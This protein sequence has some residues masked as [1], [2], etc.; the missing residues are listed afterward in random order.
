MQ[1]HR[2][3]GAELLVRIRTRPVSANMRISTR[4]RHPAQKGGW[5]AQD[6][7]AR[8]EG[9]DRAQTE[10]EGEAEEGAQRGARRP[11][12]QS[13][14]VASSRALLLALLWLEAFGH[15]GGASQFSHKRAHA[16][17]VAWRSPSPAITRTLCAHTVQSP[18]APT[19][20][21]SLPT[22]CCACTFAPRRT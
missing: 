13:R 12:G 8:L 17:S 15:T 21:C 10:Q 9:G 5:S 14:M 3:W 6:E 16:A 2:L 7:G 18:A 20:A 4:K 11:L 22:G 19:T 1:L